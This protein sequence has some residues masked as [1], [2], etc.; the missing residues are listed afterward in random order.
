MTLT[1][2]G[3]VVALIDTNEAKHE[4]CRLALPRLAKPM[5]MPGPCYTE[6][7]YLLGRELGYPGQ[8]TLWRLR[9]S[10]QLSVHEC[11]SEE[12]DR[13]ELLMEQY[14]DA[15]M[16]LADASLVVAAETLGLRR[17]FTLDRHF[18]AYR[19]ADGSALEVIP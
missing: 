12:L 2:T 16:D 4:A 1:D 15:P 14:R 9:S 6:A 7:M 3:P 8:Q 18:Y 17:V 19:L 11:S 5:V 13:M 10:G